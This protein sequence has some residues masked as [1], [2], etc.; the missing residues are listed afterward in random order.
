MGLWEYRRVAL[1]WTGGEV[2]R[3][4]FLGETMSKLNLKGGIQT[5]G[6]FLAQRQQCMQGEVNEK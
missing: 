2:V 6:T 1:V 5:R 3:K 4:F